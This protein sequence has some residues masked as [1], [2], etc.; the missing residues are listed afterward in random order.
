MVEEVKGVACTWAREEDHVHRTRKEAWSCGRETGQG[1]NHPEWQRS[2][3]VGRRLHHGEQTGQGFSCTAGA[4]REK[5]LH[6][7]GRDYRGPECPGVPGL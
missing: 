3:R 6:K 5:V 4:S 7:D 1:W 2:L